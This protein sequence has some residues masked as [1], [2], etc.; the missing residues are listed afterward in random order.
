MSAARRTV[1]TPTDR[2]GPHHKRPATRKKLPRLHTTQK[3]TKTPSKLTHAL[4]KVDKTLTPSHVTRL[5]VGVLGTITIASGGLAYAEIPKF[6][7]T[8]MAYS[9]Q[10]MQSRWDDA[11]KDMDNARAQLDD[12]NRLVADIEK[13][14]QLADHLQRPTIQE[15][16]GAARGLADKY[17]SNKVDSLQRPDCKSKKDNA[18][19]VSAMQAPA[20]KLDT[21]IR[22]AYH[23]IYGSLHADFSHPDSTL[24]HQVNGSFATA[25]DDA[26]Y[27]LRRADR[28]KH[29]LSQTT[30]QLM[31]QDNSYDSH[32]D[33]ELANKL[34]TVINHTRNSEALVDDTRNRL[35]TAAQ[36]ED[37]E[38]FTHNLLHE[39]NEF[40]DVVHPGVL[41]DVENRITEI[42]D[43]VQ[44]TD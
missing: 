34:D 5:A 4:N 7:D 23:N 43:R 37:A 13:T 22:V 31:R 41:D 11:K 10:E 24:R 20:D 42:K 9:C 30:A 17:D 29:E 26:T 6:T 18:D 21:H 15:P 19:K 28:L 38:E 40:N 33:R 27:T 35:D 14:P 2:R 25:Q 3:K 32:A 1:P 8:F 16:L 12:L 44:Q 39:L 36:S